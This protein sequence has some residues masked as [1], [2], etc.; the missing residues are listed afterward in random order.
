MY[1]AA[2]F[3]TTKYPNPNGNQSNPYSGETYSPTN[4]ASP[5]SGTTI[6]TSNLQTLKK[7]SNLQSLQN[8]N[9]SSDSP[10]ASYSSASSTS[11]GSSSSSNLIIPEIFKQDLPNYPTSTAPYLPPKP[12][13]QIQH[14]PHSNFNPIPPNYHQNQSPQYPSASY[15][16]S[17]IISA[18][19]SLNNISNSTV[20]SIGIPN[21]DQ[22]LSNN[23]CY[24]PNNSVNLKPS[25]DTFNHSNQMIPL[26]PAKPLPLLPTAP[27]SNH[28]YAPPYSPTKPHP[29]LPISRFSSYPET[30]SFT[31]YSSSCTTPS[32]CTMSQSPTTYIPQHQNNNG[33]PDTRRLSDPNSRKVATTE[34]PPS[35]TPRISNE[36]PQQIFSS[37]YIPER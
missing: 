29:P 23:L 11:T 31:C 28:C 30:S 10:R 9:V 16:A 2:P 4:Y 37:K 22:I 6:G 36:Y 27:S 35:S 3:P 13:D 15:Y 1:T 24:S 12:R 25:Q 21:S 32:Q 19:N 14:S 26:D 34:F 7:F 17:N 33:Q 8:L 5:Q 20:N 18:N